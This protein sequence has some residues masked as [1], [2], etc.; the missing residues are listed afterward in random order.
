MI[1]TN[2][3][4]VFQAITY[5]TNDKRFQNFKIKAKDKVELPYNAQYSSLEF[6]HE[7][8][9]NMSTRQMCDLYSEYLDLIEDGKLM[10]DAEYRLGTNGFPNMDQK[11]VD[12]VF[13]MRSYKAKGAELIA[14]NDANM[15]FEDV[16]PPR[17]RPYVAK[18]YFTEDPKY[19]ESQ[20]LIPKLRSLATILPIEYQFRY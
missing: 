14:D 4:V 20:E 8:I 7:D 1:S 5:A 6:V 2:Y 12:T 11:P 19:Y 17:K 3:C 13:K 16:Q 9:I 10:P 18:R 15:T